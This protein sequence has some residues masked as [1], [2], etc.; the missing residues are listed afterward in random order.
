MVAGAVVVIRNMNVREIF[1]AVIRG[2]PF[3]EPNNR[4]VMTR[5]YANASIFHKDD[6]H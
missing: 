3:L 4:E 5:W 2:T 1:D 6:S